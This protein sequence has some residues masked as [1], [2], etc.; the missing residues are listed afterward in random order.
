MGVFSELLG[1][2]LKRPTD[3]NFTTYKQTE[4]HSS[5][6]VKFAD[7]PTIKYENYN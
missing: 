3:L 5:K 6:N 1:V 7:K 4:K 2:I